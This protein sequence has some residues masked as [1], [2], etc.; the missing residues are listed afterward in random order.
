MSFT[1]L[2]QRFNERVNTLYNG[3]TTKYD[4][5]RPSAGTTDEP[6]V[7][8]R[9]GDSQCG[10]KIEGRSAPVISSANDVRRLSLF[11]IS[12][13][14]IVFLAK[15]QLLQTGNTFASTRLLNPTFVVA[16]AIPFAHVQRH[17]DT[18]DP[19]RSIGR[20]LV[21]GVLG[22]TIANRIFGSGRPVN[23]TELRKIG[24]LQKETYDR[25]APQ[26]A[27]SIVSKTIGNVIRKLPVIGKIVSAVSATRSMGETDWESSRPELGRD[28]SGY[29]SITNTRYGA[30][31]R[32]STWNGSY[33]TYLGI[34]DGQTSTRPDRLGIILSTD[35]LRYSRTRNNWREP[36]ED[37][38]RSELLST[39]ARGRDISNQK[40]NYVD[41][42]IERAI[43]KQQETFWKKI[44]PSFIPAAPG[45]FIKYFTAG[46]V[47]VTTR[48]SK[49]T[50][51]RD[52]AKD[53]PKL[54]Y[55][56]D[57]LNTDL[58]SRNIK[59]VLEPYA[60]LPVIDTPN[61]PPQDDIITVSFAMGKDSH[62][63]FRAFLTDLTQDIMPQYKPYQ[64]IGRMEKFI[65]YTGVQRDIS[66]KLKIVAFGEDELTPVWTRIN[67]LTGMAFPYGF[68]NG[69]YQPNI[70]R[71]T[72]GNVY[73]DQPAYI[74]SLNTNFSEAGESWEITQG[75][76]VPIAAT[77]AMKF[78]LIEKNT[79]TAASP[80]YHITEE[81]S[82]FKTPEPAARTTETQAPD[83]DPS[84][85]A[86][87]NPLEYQGNISRVGG[88]SIR[89]VEQPSPFPDVVRVPNLATTQIYRK[90]FLDSSV[91]PF[92]TR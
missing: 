69:I 10:L 19:I 12:T 56:R 3:A 2:E 36:E 28:N 50:N 89:R 53:K 38:Y 66:F 60:S 41:G 25:L 20:S 46:E 39:T 37:D 73:Y 16:N 58:K 87:R 81:L 22:Q 92:Q 47:A 55:V 34:T 15:Q 63:Q 13:R 1:T 35:Y 21:G 7:L 44:L 61:T 74:T 52:I 8:R 33:T 49:T 67:Y 88:G 42:Q 40:R 57:P 51:A 84:T 90:P 43:D 77:M 17:I 48:F 54:T 78:T 62:V 83:Q 70:I 91:N 9:P 11:Q 64:Y 30:V 6:Y 79:K 86:A 31:S 68:N 4:G 72:I 26:T 24:Q 80:F 45:N 27:S 5:G 59:K 32:F 29:T 82:T 75:K 76:Q 85:I 65:A 71:M 23:L 18:R 14:G